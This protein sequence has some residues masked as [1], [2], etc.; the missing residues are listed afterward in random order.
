[1]AITPADKP[2]CSPNIKPKRINR[3]IAKPLYRRFLS[4]KESLGFKL[5]SSRTY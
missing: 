2:K 3:I 1:M 4:F 5:K